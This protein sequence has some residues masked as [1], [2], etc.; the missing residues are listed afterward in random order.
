MSIVALADGQQSSVTLDVLHDVAAKNN[1]KISSKTEEDAYLL[2]LQSADMTASSVHSLPDY[3]DPR[4]EPVP[5]VGGRQ[6]WKSIHNSHNAWSHQASLVAEKPLSDVL[7]GRKIVIKDNM[8]VGGLPHTCGT[9][10][11]FISKDGKYPIARIDA[12]IIRRLLE[13]GITIVGTS[14]CENYSLTPMSYTSANGPVHNPWLRDHNAGG[15]TS[16]GACLVGLGN[17]RAAGVPG[18]DEAGEDVDLAMG[19]DQAGSI[20]LPSAYCGIYGLKPTHGLVPY[21]GIA[22]LHPM[23]DYTGP[24]ARN[25]EDIAT[26]L[27]VIAGYDGLD[28]RMSPESPLRQ[29]VVDYAKG[30]SSAE[31]PGKGLKVGIIKES[32]SSPGTQAEVA[33]TVRSTAFKH[34]EASGATVSEVSLPMHL[35]GA[36]IWTAATRTHMAELAIGGRTPDVLNHNMPHLSLR[37]PPDQEMYD[38]L[39]TANPAVINI[40][41]CQTFLKEKFGPEV[42]AKAHRHVLQLRAAYDKAL[43]EYDVLITPTTP[44]VALPHPDLRPESEGGS[45]IMDKIK[46]AVGATNNTAPFNASGHPALNVPCGWAPS[47]TGKGMLPVG[48]QIIGKRW[49]D[50]GVLKAAKAFELGGGGLGPW[51]GQKQ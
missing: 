9:F 15:S 47:R 24:M 41:F 51:P 16:G 42:Q 23:I 6:Y 17:A 14:T 38:L 34:F 12:S 21:T 36:A 22:G 33:E 30:L 46:L 37:W 2:V 31:N 48:L 29:N 26:L 10:P 8:S 39:T 40:I 19:G 43:E 11:Q 49:D 1:M 3:I 20:R 4:L 25:L 32:L 13:A 27:T 35:L 5:T 50:L 44:T 18:L 28:P 7:K 45:T